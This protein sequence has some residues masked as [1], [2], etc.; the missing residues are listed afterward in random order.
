MVRRVAHNVIL[1]VHKLA[2]SRA[3]H[4]SFLGLLG[5]F[6]MLDAH[7]GA[8]DYLFLVLAFW[9]YITSHSA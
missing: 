3:V 6:I 8:P 4:N 7:A 5:V 9:D 1:K 2:H